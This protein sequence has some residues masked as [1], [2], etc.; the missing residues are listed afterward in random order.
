MTTEPID[1]LTAA[2]MLDEQRALAHARYPLPEL[3]AA[4]ADGGH[5]AISGASGAWLGLVLVELAATARRPVIVVAPHSVDARVVHEAVESFLPGGRRAVLVPAPDVSPWS[6]ASPDRLQLLERL[7]ATRAVRDLG[8]GDVAVLPAV[9]WG[10]LQVPLEVSDRYTQTLAVNDELDLP[11]LKQMLLSAGY[12]AVSLVEDPG[13]FSF[14]GDLV[15]IFS[16]DAEKPVRIE[17]YGDLVESIREY[18]PQTQRSGGTLEHV[19]VVPARE[20]IVGPEAIATARRVLPE[21]AEQLRV[22]S[23][24]VQA[25]L[26]DLQAGVRFFGV[27]FLL[28]AFSDR[29]EPLAERVD[30]G[31][32]VVVVNP[33]G[34][35]D[36]YGEFLA[37]R[38]HEREREAEM[39]E[40]AFEV[41]RFFL[42]E[43]G[44]D[45]ALRRFGRRVDA[46]AVGADAAAQTFSFPWLDNAAV[47][48]ARRAHQ[49]EQGGLHGFIELVDSWREYYGRVVFLAA[50]RGA[51]ERMARLLRPHHDNVVVHDAGFDLL[52][53]RSPPAQAW[54]VAVGPLREGFRSPARSLAVFTEAEIVGRASRKAGK[55]ALDEANAISS[56]KDLQPGDLLVHVDFGIGRYRGLERMDAGGA[57]ADFLAIEYADNDRLYLPVYRMG[58]VS[59]YVGTPGLTRLDKLG[60][61]TWEKTRERV[62]R[63][64]ADIAGELLRVQAER[65]ARHGFAFSAPDELYREFEAA[66]PYE[67]TP[68]QQSAID[69]AIADMMSDR[70]MDRLLCGDVG[71]G[72]TEVAIRAAYKAVVD[73]RQVAVL[74]PTTVLAEQHGKSFRDRLANTAARVE[75]VSRFRSAAEVK[76]ILADVAAGKIDV[77]IGTH[78]LLSDDVKWR[79]LGL[80]V[81]DEEHR[82][83]VTHK[84]K[85]KQLRASIDVLTMT[86]TPIPR[87]LEMSLLGIRDLSV[88]MTPPPGRLAVRTHIAKFRDEILREGIAA[89]LK[90]GG[91][92][93]FVHNRVETIY[94][95]AD[96]LRKLLPDAKIVVGHA[97]LPDAELEDV[98]HRFLSREANVLV[99]TTIIESGI[100]VSTANTIFINEAHRFG[101]AQLHQLRGRVGRS[102]ERAYCYLL[103]PDPNRLTP[104][105]KRRLEVVQ[106]HAELGAGMQIAQQDLDMRGAG[107]VLG[108]DQSGHIESVGF[109]LFSE[110][111]QEA[112]AELKGMPLDDHLEPEVKLPIAAFIPED[113]VD[114]VG[115]RLAFYKRLSLADD[116]VALGDVVAELEDRYGKAPDPVTSL[117]DVVLLKQQMKT[118]RAARLEGGPKSIVVGL[119][120]DT[121]LDPGRVMAL[122]EAN[123]GRYEFRPDMTLVRH[124]KGPESGDILGSALRVAREVHTCIASS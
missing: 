38:R 19:R 36:A 46:G 111:L 49:G 116:E 79:S 87:T 70:P 18:D 69:D 10:R 108:R 26:R 63:Q 102:S 124:L 120:P 106:E 37:S 107:N 95:V 101:L 84:E 4:L 110:L 54:E 88:I 65:Q 91:Q 118:I 25:V 47:V 3:C 105:A 53:R 9:A 16:P 57:Q 45:A 51:A 21:L 82:F 74:V 104:E 72:K 99:T 60:G 61:S 33:E 6:G 32:I 62:K 59:R 31:A 56:F 52:E 66:F 23:T 92:V 123:R 85:L 113:Y 55:A 114:D 13:T 34:V 117:R 30:S 115:Q 90:R 83:G 44:F 1:T 78:R 5:A 76:A 73:H 58:R 96:E 75:V 80:L 94:G 112:I 122:I 29:L 39:G 11:A 7:A 24:R 22:P 71:F 48:R 68:H 42:D 14:R 28:P 12:T 93:F 98:M 86:A 27:E 2:A 43:P 119:L 15:D 50:T 67:T 64:L 8:P 81:I 100:D 35:R 41:E 20:E 121:R 77:V 109:E 97:Q 89:E 40:L 17:L 103:V